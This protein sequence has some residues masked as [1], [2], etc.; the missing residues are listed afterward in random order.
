M[1]TQHT[2]GPLVV[3][4]VGTDPPDCFTV[5]EDRDGYGTLV[6]ICEGPR[7]EANAHLIA[8]APDLLAALSNLVNATM[9]FYEADRMGT[10]HQAKQELFDIANNAQTTIAKAQGGSQ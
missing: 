3:R 5:N 7:A 2:P 6:A 9:A 8:A 4:R 1:G 10:D